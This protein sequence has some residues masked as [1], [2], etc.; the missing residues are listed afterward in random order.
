LSLSA[1]L[2]AAAWD[3]SGSFAILQRTNRLLKGFLVG[4]SYAHYLTYGPHLGAELVLHAFELLKGPT[5]NL[6]TT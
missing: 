5:Q 3:Q 2:L 6:T 1:S 4:L